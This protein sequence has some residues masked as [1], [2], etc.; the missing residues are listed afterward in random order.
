[1]IFQEMGLLEHA[2]FL[3][4]Q[5]ILLIGAVGQKGE[6]M[7]RIDGDALKE[8]IDYYIR[9]AGWGETHNEALR[10][11]LEFIDNQPTIEPEIVHCEDCKWRNVYRF[12]PKYDE[13]DYC[14]EHEKTVSAD[15][16]CSWAERRTDDGLNQPTG[17]D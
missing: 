5:C 17:C 8:E 12:P 1:M 11:C 6:R 15:G 16:F 14:D 4:S 10:W 7:K 13:R 3:I 2:V 9:E